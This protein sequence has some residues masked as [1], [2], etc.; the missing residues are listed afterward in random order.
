MHAHWFICPLEHKC[1]LHAKAISM[2]LGNHEEKW[3]L[4]P[5][6]GEGDHVPGF[7]YHLIHDGREPTF[8]EQIIIYLTE[9]AVM[10][11]PTSASNGLSKLRLAEGGAI[12]QLLEQLSSRLKKV[13][14]PFH[15]GISGEI[16]EAISLIGNGIV[17]E[18]GL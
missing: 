8:F 2:P 10:D 6:V 3:V 18:E 5:R 16:A 1:S 12:I 7:S 9:D 15:L 14:N 11:S 4:V 17:I 13:V